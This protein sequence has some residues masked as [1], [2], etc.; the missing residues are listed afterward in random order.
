M[1]RP[2]NVWL[3]ENKAPCPGLPGPPDGGM[4]SETGDQM[5]IAVT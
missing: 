5:F 1:Q 2:L 4:L 3:M